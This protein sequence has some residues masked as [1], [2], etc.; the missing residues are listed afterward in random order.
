M[1]P[2]ELYEPGQL[3]EASDILFSYRKKALVLAG[4]LDLVSRMRRW[5]IKPE[6]LVSIRRI[7]GLDYI[8][9]RGK[10]GTAIGAMASIRSLELSPLIQQ[11]YPA[12]Y[13]AVRQFAS[14]Q[15]K[16]MGT[17]VGNLCVGTPA[18]DIVPNLYAL[19]ASLKIAGPDA[20]RTIPIEEFY[21]G[22][23]KTVL[24]PGEI[25][26]EVVIPGA[27]SGRSGVFLKL[28]KTKADIA[29]VNVTVTLK[30]ADGMCR[31]ARIALGSV[32]PTVIRA[33]KAEELV[34]GQKLDKELL[35]AVGRAAAA[36][37]KPITD[38]RS[39][40]EYRQEM[41]AV[42]VRRAV[43]MAWPKSN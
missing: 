29:K 18:S 19:D 1:R 39:T 26:T 41:V 2:F 25:V 31:E 13:S 24:K 30:I 8:K 22:T 36:E 28:E 17:V 12:L 35:D 33:V 4:G 21:A 27:A 43:A 37:A 42:L 34:R 11:D 32:A 23:G 9:S 3:S 7:P 5:Q 38:L 15:V 6:Y 14:V 40:R 10:A 16:T 20:E